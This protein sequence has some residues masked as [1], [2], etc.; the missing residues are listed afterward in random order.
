MFKY[1]VT[2]ALIISQTIATASEQ[3]TQTVSPVSTYQASY[4]ATWKA[5]WFPITVD[6]SR[7]L[8]QLENGQWQLTF[9][10]YSSIA[11][12]HEESQYKIENNT[13]KPQNYRYKTSGFL[14]KKRRAQTFDWDKKQVWVPERDEWANYELTLGI[15]DNLSYQEQIRLDLKAGKTEFSYAVAYK[16]RLKHYDFKVVK[17]SQVKTKQGKINTV[18]VIQTKDNKKESTRIW[19]AVDYDYLLI[20]LETKQS[21]GDSNTITLK[22]A[23]IK[24]KT[25]KGF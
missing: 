9:E 19:F 16:N 2:I 12:L 15:Q 21:N 18:E 7:S 11:D 23:Q 8:T 4:E 10:A 1:I 17:H 24:D 6:A 22:E 14:S 20:K 3:T 5:G 13:I 25:I